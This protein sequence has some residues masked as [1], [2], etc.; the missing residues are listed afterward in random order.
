M[1][2]K[3]R[4]DKLDLLL[5][6]KETRKIK[7]SELCCLEDLLSTCKS[8]NPLCPHISKGGCPTLL[9]RARHEAVYA[10]IEQCNLN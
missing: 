1:P 2:S 6:E 10:F 7:T 5:L 4:I 9:D 8:E 3:K